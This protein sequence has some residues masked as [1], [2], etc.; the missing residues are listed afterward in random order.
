[1]LDQKDAQNCDPVTQT[2]REIANSPQSFTVLIVRTRFDEIE[3][4]ERER[5]IVNTLIHYYCYRDKNR[6]QLT[7]MQT[8]LVNCT[9]E[10]LKIYE[11]RFLLTPEGDF[12]AAI[13]DLWEI[14]QSDDCDPGAF[15]KEE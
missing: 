10:T 15:K 9:F 8:V 4:T 1:M 3:L 6:K 2:C 13:V 11:D 14:L 12:L 5:T 7:P